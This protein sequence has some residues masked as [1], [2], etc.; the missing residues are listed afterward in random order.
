[1][2]LVSWT[3]TLLSIGPAMGMPSFPVVPTSLL[4]FVVAWAVGMVAMMF[5]T[6]VPMLLMFFNVGKN[7][8]EEIKMGGGPTVTKAL[9]FVGTYIG[10]WITTGV[11][12]YVAIALVFSQ[13][14]IGVDLFI[15]TSGGLGAALI[16]VAVYQLSPVKGECL[17]RCHP[18]SFLFI[19]YQG[20]LIGSV[21]MGA[22]YAKYCVGCCW[23]MMIFLVVSASMGVAWMAAFA[24]IIFVERTFPLR[25]WMPR[26]IGLGF[27][28]GGAALIM[29]G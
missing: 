8:S 24:S 2:A 22:D 20:G 23:V 11:T 21:R 19:Y 7:S 1:M 6:A 10:I 17:G 18:N 13:L 26:L 16:L 25:R 9:L 4:F 28:I 15:G 14:P 29:V 12:L 27:L 5:P 3:L